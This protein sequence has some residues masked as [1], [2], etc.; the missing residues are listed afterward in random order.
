MKNLEIED[1]YIEENY[2]YFS[3]S[4]SKGI[5][6][7]DITDGRVENY[8]YV[9][10]K[11]D[12]MRGRG[13]KIDRWKDRIVTSP[14][15]DNKIWLYDQ[16]TE[17]WDYIL[18][19][20]KQNNNSSVMHL[21]CMYIDEDKM[22]LLGCHYPAVI[23]VNLTSKEVKE[24]DYPNV[25]NGKDRGR[26]M[27]RHGSVMIGRK[28]YGYSGRND[29]FIGFDINNELVNW[30]PCEK[31]RE[32]LDK[33]DYIQMKARN[34]KYWH[35]Y[36]NYLIIQD[37]NNVIHY[38]EVNTQKEKVFNLQITQEQ[39][40]ESL[41]KQF[42]RNTLKNGGILYES[43]ITLKSFLRTISDENI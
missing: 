36:G 25:T 21:F 28:I 42:V 23:V 20:P 26:F 43:D 11:M 12:S 14:G 3:Q 2:F 15:S 22:Y 6:R 34:Y 17:N 41:D 16:K 37:G 4:A 35:Q 27:Y 10:G 1:G 7:Q 9:P 5:F 32:I 24:I 8:V 39:W 30:I 29:V 19:A 13:L 33:I 40:E 31:H 18:L 38:I